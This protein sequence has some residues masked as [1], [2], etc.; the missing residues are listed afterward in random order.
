[1]LFV[2]SAHTLTHFIFA[3][4]VWNNYE[5]YSSSGTSLNSP[6]PEYSGEAHYKHPF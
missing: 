1:M 4:N 6:S 3:M 5:Q 2:N